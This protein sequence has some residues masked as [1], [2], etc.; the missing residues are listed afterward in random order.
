[1]TPTLPPFELR[2]DRT[3]IIAELSANHGGDL[4]RAIETI[5]LAAE[6][7]ADAIK[8]QTYRADTITLNSDREEFQIRDGLWAGRTLHQLYHEAHTPWEWHEDLQK[9]AHRVGLPMFSS[10]FDHT[11]VDFLEGLGVPAYKV[12]SFEITDLGLIQKMA[13]TKKPMIMSTG[14]SSLAEIDDAVRTIRTE[15]GATDYG[16]SIL[17]CVSAYPAPA[18]SMNL[19]TIPHLADAFGVLP[20]LS[21][22]T[23]GISVPVAAVALG[24]RVIEKHFIRSRTDGGPDSSFSIEPKEWADMVKAV[25]TIEEAVGQVSYGPTSSEEGSL[26]F[27][28]S[29]WLTK[30]L[31]AGDRI[32]EDCIKVARPGNGLAPKNLRW[33]LGRRVNAACSYGTPL[34]LELID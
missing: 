3:F 16:L 34:T 30:E 26:R 2:S 9:A 19:R 18:S 22:H 20:G 4:Q 10:P 17:K 7:G 25:R 5:E 11:A 1:M 21:D 15:W 12:A 31:K 33:V 23:L 32:T 6:A 28:R 29:I 24:A 14:M 8:L 27:R 13:S